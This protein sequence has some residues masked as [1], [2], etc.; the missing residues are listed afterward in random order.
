M[1]IYNNI[2]FDFAVNMNR[3]HYG[4]NDISGLFVLKGAHLFGGQLSTQC[5]CVS[6]SVSP[7]K[8]RSE[9]SWTAVW[10]AKRQRIMCS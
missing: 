3:H 8:R 7:I 5:V 6:G 4:K 9:G 1:E 10:S 2:P